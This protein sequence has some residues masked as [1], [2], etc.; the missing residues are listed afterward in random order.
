MRF[1]SCLLYDVVINKN[2][3]TVKI[4]FKTQYTN[5]SAWPLLKKGHSKI[6]HKN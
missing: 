2:E 4:S 1:E 6:P 3:E 5:K